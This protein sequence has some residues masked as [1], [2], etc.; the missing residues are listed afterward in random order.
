M[1][2]RGLRIR[3]FEARDQQAARQLIL[4]G[5]G[6]HFGFL[7]ETLNPDLNDILRTY[8]EQGEI[9]LVAEDEEGNIVGTGALVREAG[10]VG[11]IV[12]V[13]VESRQRRKGIGRAMVQRLL[14]LARQRG[15]H[16]VVLSTNLGWDD[17]IGL[18]RSLGFSGYERGGNMHMD[19]EL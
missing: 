3:P 9:F 16:R 4:N 11:R 17:A 14:E 15:Y 6:G 2:E 13:S 10:G 5:L 8:V 18:Y 12:R 19:L 7:D 1:A